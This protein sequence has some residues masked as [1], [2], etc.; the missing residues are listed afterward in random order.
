MYIYVCI[1]I[2]AL[3]LPMVP[4]LGSIIETG[5]WVD[6]EEG[7]APVWIEGRGGVEK[8]VTPLGLL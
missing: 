7:G 8:Q 4:V 1:Y 6:S 2:Q 3:P 5:G